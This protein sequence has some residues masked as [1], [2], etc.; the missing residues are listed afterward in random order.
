MDFASRAARNEEIVRGV[1]RQIEAGAE[2]HGVR[3]A[4]PFHW[5]C[6]QEWCVEKIDLDAEFYEPILA[7]RYHFLVVPD[8][9]VPSVE[10]VV[11]RGP[12]DGV[13]SPVRRGR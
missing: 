12:F 2:I 7:E 9:V 3:S 6:A 4:M 11:D 1:N 10:R 5:E 13:R 8:H